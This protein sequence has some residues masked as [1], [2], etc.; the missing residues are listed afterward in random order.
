ML[1]AEIRGKYEES[2]RN[3][4]DYLTSTVFSH[5][6][7]VSP[8]SFWS[9]LLGKARTLPV[10]GTERLFAEVLGTD[11][12][13][14]SYQTLKVHFWPR[15]AGLGEPELAL[16]FTG[17]SQKPLVVLVEVK[18]WASKSGLGEHDQLMRYLRIADQIHLLTPV[19][20]ADSKVAVLYLTPREAMTEVQ[21]SLSAAGDTLQ[22]RLR[23]FRLQWQDVLNVIT[24]AVEAESEFN[25]LILKDVG[26]FLRARRLE[27]FGGFRTTPSSER[28]RGWCGSFLSVER[29]F[30]GFTLPPEVREVQVVRGAWCDGN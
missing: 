27:Y 10:E 25:C 19:V 28:L 30:K 7:Y 21:D 18:L 13:V 1:L 20:P 29:A 3:N 16:C 4:E 11:Y 8:G 15:C 2:A 5:L 26:E 22:N 24:D 23:L 17:E 14:N 9:T 12:A 6:R